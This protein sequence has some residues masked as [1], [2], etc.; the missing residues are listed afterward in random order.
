MSSDNRDPLGYYA[1]LAVDPDASM[2]EIRSAFE[3]AVATAHI[4]RMPFVA[5]LAATAYKV[6]S[7]EA[8]R[9]KYDKKYKQASN[10]NQTSGQQPASTNNNRIIG[11][12]ADLSD[13]KYHKP[14]SWWDKLLD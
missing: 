9:R 10:L 6:L 3:R 1:M 13:G 5:E 12:I 2:H 4:N 7:D 11:S 8:T 14:K